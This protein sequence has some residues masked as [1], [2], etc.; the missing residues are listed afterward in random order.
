MR[1]FLLLL[2]RLLFS[3]WISLGSLARSTS[4]SWLPILSFSS[5]LSKAW[6]ASVSSNVQKKVLGVRI[7]S[8]YSCFTLSRSISMARSSSLSAIFSALARLAKILSKSRLLKANCTSTI[9]VSEEF[10]LVDEC[11][12]LRITSIK[13]ALNSL[14][15]IESPPLSL[16]ARNSS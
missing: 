13:L 5:R 10:K 2:A 14:I 7:W 1:H 8:N 12:L 9:S 3:H 16:L 6:Q 4:I 11:S 15:G